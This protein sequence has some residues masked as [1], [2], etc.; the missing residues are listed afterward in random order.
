[1]RNEFSLA[2]MFKLRGIDAGIWSRRMLECIQTKIQILARIGKTNT[3][4]KAFV[5]TLYYYSFSIYLPDSGNE[6]ILHIDLEETRT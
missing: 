3:K 4:Q 1:M 2:A 5:N 6:I